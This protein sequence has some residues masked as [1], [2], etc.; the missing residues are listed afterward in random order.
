MYKL[1]VVDDEPILIRGIRSFVDFEALS[2]TEVMEAADGEEALDLFKTHRPD[3]VLADINMPKMNGLDFASAAKALKPNVKIAMIT[4]YD[5][6]DYAVA[7]LKTGV[8]DY[9]LKPVSKKDIQELLQ[10]LVGKVHEAHRQEEVTKLIDGLVQSV[11]SGDETTG[12]KYKIQQEIN[13]N[14]DNI[15]FSLATLA[16]KLA[17]SPSYVSTLFKQ[18]FGTTF[19][20]YMIAA[21]LDRAKLL[22]LSTEMKMYEIAA[23]VGFED[24]NY[25]S[26]AFKKRFSMSPNHFK[27]KSR[28]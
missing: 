13:S 14:I 1:L 28:Q 26:A 17:L 11:D 22:L 12:Y 15:D 8:D 3:L 20:Q 19:Q 7:A 6:F 5:Y 16:S 23:S 25:F 10:K 4:G 9:V 2:I 18:L 21:R 27:E 24:P